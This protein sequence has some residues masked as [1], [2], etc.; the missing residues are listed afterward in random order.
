MDFVFD[1]T[2]DFA[3]AANP[4]VSREEKVKK[5]KEKVKRAEHKRKASANPSAI[6]LKKKKETLEK[7]ALVTAGDEKIDEEENNS[8]PQPLV[9]PEET[10][11]EAR[12]RKGKAPQQPVEPVPSFPQTYDVDEA[13]LVAM[14]GGQLPQYAPNVGYIWQAGFPPQYPDSVAMHLPGVSKTRDPKKRPEE[15]DAFSREMFRATQLPYMVEEMKTNPELVIGRATSYCFEMGS[16]LVHLWDD[17]KKRQGEFFIAEMDHTKLAGAKIENTWW[18]NCALAKLRESKKA[19]NELRAMEHAKQIAEE[20]LAAHT[21]A[22]SAL[23]GENAALK[24]DLEASRRRE[25]EMSQEMAGLHQKLADANPEGLAQRFLASRAFSNAAMLSCE[26]MMKYCLYQEF[27]KLGKVYPFVPEQLG[28]IELPVEMARPKSLRGY[29]W[30]IHDDL[31]V[32]PDGAKLTG[33]HK[34]TLRS[35]P[36]TM[37]LYPWPKNAFPKDPTIPP[38]PPRRLPGQQTPRLKVNVGGSS[39]ATPSRS[40]PPRRTETHTEA[41]VEEEP[42][43]EPGKDGEDSLARQGAFLILISLYASC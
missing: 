32:N 31:L 43:K 14:L 2:E 33:T 19:Q 34:I 28:Y 38:P 27:R 13:Q 6:R 40:S 4:L 20:E 35:Q 36:G 9:L 16:M 37:I 3:V 10:E 1:S 29:S 41:P 22:L 21:V 23:E 17:L 7:Q 5:A 15:A 39:Q 18:K 42:G 24:Q 12:A 26:D 8:P 11:E 25:E 30:N